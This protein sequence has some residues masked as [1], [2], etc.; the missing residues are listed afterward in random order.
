MRFSRVAME[1]T[2]VPALTLLGKGECQKRQS[3]RCGRETSFD[4]T[5]GLDRTQYDWRWESLL[6]PLLLRHLQALEMG[7]RK[8]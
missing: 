3:R 8:R 6:R 2:R 4:R 7:M 1:V 5:G